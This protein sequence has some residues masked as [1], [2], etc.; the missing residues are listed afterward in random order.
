[1]DIN[2]SCENCT[3][4]TWDMEANSFCC[5]LYGKRTDGIGC[6]YWTEYSLCENEAWHN[7]LEEL[8]NE[9]IMK[10]YDDKNGE[11]SFDFKEQARHLKKQH[12]NETWFEQFK[13]PHRKSF[14][15]GVTFFLI[16]VCSIFAGVL[17]MFLTG[18]VD[19]IGTFVSFGVLVSLAIYL[20]KKQ[21][22]KDAVARSY[23][24]VIRVPLDHLYPLEEAS[25]REVL[26]S[27]REKTEEEL[28]INC[29]RLSLCNED[30]GSWECHFESF[31]VLIS[32]EIAR[33]WK[34]DNCTNWIPKISD[35]TSTATS[36]T[37]D[38]Q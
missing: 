1:M 27:I 16:F 36:Q 4:G 30:S 25:R 32:D 8:P 6:R 14:K 35:Q 17:A 18:G 13:R 11:S 26:S 34:L 12:K 24:E 28:C 7:N 9:N 33:N 29:D 20:D 19:F 3:S 38:R 2:Q 23:L 15:E 5:D 37:K 22:K 10:T 31:P 21:K